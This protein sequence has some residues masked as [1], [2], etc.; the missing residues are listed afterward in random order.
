MIANAAISLLL[1][2]LT[3][4]LILRLNLAW[5]IPD[6]VLILFSTAVSDILSQ[7]LTHL[8]LIV[9]M[10]K[11]CP[12]HIE[13]TSLALLTSAHNLRIPV[14]SWIGAWINKRWVGVTIDDLSRYWVLVAISY[15]CSVLPLGFIWLV[16]TRGAIAEL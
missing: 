6:M 15:G 9:V 7:C 16:P 1:A 14:S 4:I 10:S 12:R 5:G 2:P 13:A 11:I 8:P 3:F